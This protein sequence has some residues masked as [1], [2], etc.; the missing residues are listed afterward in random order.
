MLS[1]LSDLESFFGPF[2]L[3]RYLTFRGV[4]AAATALVIGYAIAPWMIRRLRL[5]KMDQT[6]RNAQEVGELADLHHSKAGTPT[7]GGL[8]LFVPIVISTILWAEPNIYV[9]VALLVYTVLSVLGF[10]DDYL[11]V[12]KK[13]TKGVPGRLK[14]LCQFGL[15]CLVLVLLLQDSSSHDL[16]RELWLPFLKEPL[17][18]QMPIW[19]MLLFMFLVLAGSSNAINLTDGIDGLAIGCTITVVLVYGIMAYATGHAII[20][21]YLFLGHVPGSGELAIVCTAVLGASMAFLWYNAYPA[22]IFMG[23]TGSLALGGL[24]GVI[25]FMV[26]QPV[27]LIIVGGIF[28]MEAGSVMLQVASYRYTGRRLFRM[29]PIHHHF[30]LK[31]WAEPKVVIRFWLISLFFAIAGLSTLKLR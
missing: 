5:F 4:M 30:E 3:F 23:D 10:A 16:M 1:Y 13:N 28:V 6:F 29:S 22:E 8:I 19:F 24:I 15:V 27:T 21:D 20:A 17:V 26:H 18:T 7:M 2:R 25:A 9:L 11:K 14:L 31:G 12:S